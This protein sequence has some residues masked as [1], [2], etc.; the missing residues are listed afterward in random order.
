MKWDLIFSHIMAATQDRVPTV[1]IEDG[2]VLGLDTTDPIEVN[3][4]KNFEGLPT[5][6]I[7]QN[8]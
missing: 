2:Y 4:W 7:I 5:G 8:Y 6:K 1:Y 3:Y